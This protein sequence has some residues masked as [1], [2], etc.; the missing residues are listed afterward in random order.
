M[1][2]S[3]PLQVRNVMSRDVVSVSLADSL[4]DALELIVA[5][6]VSGLPVVNRHDQCVGMLSMS[7]LIELTHEMDDDVHSLGSNEYGGSFFERLSEELGAERVSERMSKNVVTVGPEVK[8]TEAAGTMLSNRV[9]RLPVVDEAQQLLGI[10]STTDIVSAVAA[11]L[12]E[13]ADPHPC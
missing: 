1:T 10:L 9:H 3:H 6:R 4:H 11:G 12:A 8:L 2:M 5:N 13:P 7:D